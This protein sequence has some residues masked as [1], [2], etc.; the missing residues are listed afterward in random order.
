M[1]SEY[2]IINIEEG[3]PRVEQAIKKLTWHL[4]YKKQMGVVAVKI[5]HG[6]GSS[7][8]GGS[9]RVKSREYLASLNRR[10]VIKAFVPGESFSIFDPDSRRMLDSCPQLRRDSDLE[11]HNNGITMV[12]L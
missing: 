4:H 10:G 9:I 12:L 11:R 1:P 6:F 2:E 7:G 8:A 5:I 3:M